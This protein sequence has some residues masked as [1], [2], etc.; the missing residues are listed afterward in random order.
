VR[1]TGWQAWPE[2]ARTLTQEGIQAMKG[3][4]VG[5]HLL[6]EAN[7]CQKEQRY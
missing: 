3:Q 4:V 5:Q 7:H 1:E 2:Q 6:L